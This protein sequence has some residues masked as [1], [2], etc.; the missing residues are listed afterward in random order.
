MID[1]GHALEAEGRL[2]EA[3]QRYLE[4]IRI[5]PNPARAHLNRDNVLLLKGELNGALSISGTL[6][7]IRTPEIL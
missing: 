1:A 5:A 4:A 6:S 7:L 3:M 2:D